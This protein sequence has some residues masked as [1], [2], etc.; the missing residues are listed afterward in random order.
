MKL[1]E[2]LENYLKIHTYPSHHCRASRT[3][4]RCTVKSH[5]CSPLCCRSSVNLISINLSIRDLTFAVTEK[6]GLDISFAT[7]YCYCVNI[8]IYNVDSYLKPH[9]SLKQMVNRINFALGKIES[10]DQH[11]STLRTLDLNKN[12][13]R[14][15]SCWRGKS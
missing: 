12:R 7:M 1:P 8:G 3:T 4:A 10:H 11:T 5:T 13:R 6:C 15:S 14:N 9:L 2:Y